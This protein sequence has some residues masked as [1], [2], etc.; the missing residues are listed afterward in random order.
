MSV[1]KNLSTNTAEHSAVETIAQE[2]KA[3]CIIVRAFP[4]PE[5]TTFYTSE[6]FNLQVGK[7]VYGAATEIPR[8]T[9]RQ[10]TRTVMGTSE[11]IIVQKGRAIL[12]VYDDTRA[13]VASREIASGDVVALIGG[14]HGFRLLEDTVLIEVKQG[15]YSGLQE[16][17]RF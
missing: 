3:L 5:A 10:V 14:G 1:C 9:H 15:P 17:D 6:T 4:L 2:G 16:K 7:I 11:V 13:R 8:H 12:D